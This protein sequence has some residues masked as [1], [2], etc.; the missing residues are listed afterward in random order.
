MV[1]ILY[2]G[3][4]QTAQVVVQIEQLQPEQTVIGPKERN[5]QGTV[6]VQGPFFPGVLLIVD[7]G[8]PDRRHEKYPRKLRVLGSFRTSVQ[9]NSKSVAADT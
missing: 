4:H 5:Q 7:C 2:L 9:T 1:L 6:D 3:K 8:S